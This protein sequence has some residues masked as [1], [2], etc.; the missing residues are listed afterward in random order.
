MDYT[1]DVSFWDARRWGWKNFIYDRP[2]D[3]QRS[4]LPAA[5]IKSSQATFKD[6][7]FDVQWEAAKGLPRIAYHYLWGL[8]GA[9]EAMSQREIVGELGPDDRLALDFEHSSLLAAHYFLITIERETGKKPYLYTYPSWWAAQGGLNAAWAKDYPL[10][11]AQWPYDTKTQPAVF[12]GY[13]MNAIKV[14]IEAGTLKPMSLKPWDKA[15]IWQFTSRC[16]PDYIPGHPG[17]KKVV[18][19]DAI[20]TPW[21]SAPEPPEGSVVCP[22]CGWVF[23]P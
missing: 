20:F 6:P 10:W 7:A 13:K 12:D 8:D 9:A 17:I 21:W 23:V 11:L 3:W 22:Q 15:D 18:D 5:I 14:Q 2:T 16:S 1:I 4:G 19:Y